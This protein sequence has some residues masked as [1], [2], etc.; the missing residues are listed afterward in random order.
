VEV[1]TS[2]TYHNINTRENGDVEVV[3][4]DVGIREVDGKS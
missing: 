1:N 4:E 3:G 2:R